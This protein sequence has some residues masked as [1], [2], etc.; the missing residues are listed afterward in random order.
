M[1]VPVMPPPSAAFTTFFAF[2]AV[3]I[4]GADCSFTAGAWRVS[5]TEEGSALSLVHPPSRTAID[6]E[7]VFEGAAKLFAATNRLVLKDAANHEVGSVGFPGDGNQLELC[8]V[9]EGEA[10]KGTFFFDGHIQ[11]RADAFACSVVPLSEEEVCAF[12]LNDADSRL[13]DALYSPANDEA[14]VTRSSGATFRAVDGG[15]YELAFS[16][17]P[18]SPT[19]AVAEFRVARDYY[20]RRWAPAYRPGQNLPAWKGLLS[21]FPFFDSKSP[22]ERE[23]VLQTLALFLKTPGVRPTALY[24]LESVPCVWNLGIRRESIGQDRLVAVFNTLGDAQECSVDWGDLG[25]DDGRDFIVYDLWNES[26]LGVLQTRFRSQVPAKS[27]QLFALKP[28]LGRPQFLAF[29][30]AGNFVRGV[31][32][33]SWADDVLSVTFDL[34]AGKQTTLR[35]AVPESFTLG[36]ISAPPSVTVAAPRREAGGKVVA[37]TLSSSSAADAT[38]LRLSFK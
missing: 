11:Y 8:V 22:Q 15:R 31:T 25:E 36:G 7:F 35:F 13:N 2:V 5:Y 3:L 38:T 21:R 29:A 23:H 37:V 14:F 19:T 32:R 4:Y 28:Y 34:P 20:R 10:Q 26:W 9:A 24:P 6:G 33:E 30:D 27:V 12:S 1:K 16:L 18:A 17:V